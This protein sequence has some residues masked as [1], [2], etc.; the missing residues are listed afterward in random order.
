MEKIIKTSKT[1]CVI[2]KVL[3]YPIATVGTLGVVAIVCVSLFNGVGGN[4]RLLV[5]EMKAQYYA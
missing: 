4:S 2:L 5:S 3:Y 1:I